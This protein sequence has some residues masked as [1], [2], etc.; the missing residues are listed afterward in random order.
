MAALGLV[1]LACTKGTS[2]YN[3]SKE[4][5]YD[6]GGI[7]APDGAYGGDTGGGQGGNFDA[8]PG[9]I[10]AAEWNDLLNWEFWGGL[11]TGN[12]SSY[13]GY[14][15]FNTSKRIAVKTV[16]ANG[17]PA[18]CLPVK[19]MKGEECCWETVT[20]NSGEANLWIA[21]TDIQST[22]SVADLGLGL[23]AGTRGEPVYGRARAV[24][25]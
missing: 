22:V 2:D 19:L 25:Q 17:N 6:M 18:K 16:D 23:P 14:W 21:A 1:A 8:E 11:M 15:G 12:F 5:A 7:S 10:T 3:V 20:D 9:V 24:S 13:N 4:D